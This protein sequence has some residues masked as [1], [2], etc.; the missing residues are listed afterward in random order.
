MAT[1]GPGRG[2]VCSPSLGWMTEDEGEAVRPAKSA[3]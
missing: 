1:G 3:G 2:E